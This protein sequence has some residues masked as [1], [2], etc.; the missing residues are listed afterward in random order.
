M[1]RLQFSIL[2]LFGWFFVFYNIERLHAPI[3]LASFVYLLAPT[4]GMVMLCI[5]KL[6]RMPSYWYLPFSLLAVLALREVFGYEVSGNAVSLAVVEGLATWT[7]IWLSSELAE[8]IDEYQNAAATAIFS[9]VTGSCRP[10]EEVQTDIIREVRRARQFER[11][12]AVLALKPIAEDEQK[13]LDRFSDEFKSEL[14]QQYV[15]ARAADCVSSQLR[16]HDILTQTNDQFLA[17]LPEM[18][19]ADGEKL[20]DKMRRELRDQ[21]GIDLAVGISMFPEEE[22]TAIGLVERA[23]EEVARVRELAAT[24]DANTATNVATESLEQSVPRFNTANT[25]DAQ[26]RKVEPLVR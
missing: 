5:P 21:L 3:N 19:R 17:L 4:L 13:T 22:V 6:H 23:Q 25:S 14:L 2:A 12:I 8:G 18:N 1:K 11:P 15:S 9:H 20:A 24:T 10:F 16:Q 26:Q 7:T